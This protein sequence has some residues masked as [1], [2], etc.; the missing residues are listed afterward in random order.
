MLRRA[1]LYRYRIPLSPPLSSGGRRLSHREGL[2]VRLE[3]GE[4]CGMGEVAPLPGFSRESLWQ[5]QRELLQQL[6]RWVAGFGVHCRPPSAA[7]GLSCALDELRQGVPL[8][9]VD[10]LSS[11]YPLLSGDPEQIVERWHHWPE[12][13]PSLVKLKL[14]RRP[15]EAEQTMVGELLSI[16]PGLRFRIDANRRWSPIDARRWVDWLGRERIDYLEEPCPRLWQ[17]LQLADTCGVD[18]ALDES[19]RESLHN[20]RGPLPVHPCFKVAV[21]KPSLTGPL[22]QIERLI[23]QC[24]RRGITTLLSSSYES[25][26]GIGQLQALA[27]RLTPDQGPGLDTLGP[28]S[29]HLLR[30]AA[31]DHACLDWAQLECL[32]QS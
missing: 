1:A 13:R 11:G 15:V 22:G 9:L 25:S 17:S 26:L 21:I 4:R 23:R 29:H 18:L 20:G 14:G 5:A 16:S 10:P 6:P 12:P 3:Q 8:R 27:R 32:W 7:F 30:P 24:R 19:L 28:F 31:G 2:V